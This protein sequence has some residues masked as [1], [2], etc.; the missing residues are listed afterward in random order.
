MN[1]ISNMWNSKTLKLKI[2]T[3]EN[4]KLQNFKSIIYYKYKRYNVHDVLNKVVV[5]ITL[6]LTLKN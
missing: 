5:Y 6:N 1:T 4:S 3:F 2:C